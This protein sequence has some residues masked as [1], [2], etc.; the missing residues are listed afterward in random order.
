MAA[1]CVPERTSAASAAG[2]RAEETAEVRITED[3]G[4]LAVVAGSGT[5]SAS[6]P[7]PVATPAGAFDPLAPHTV[8]KRNGKYRTY[9]ADS[10]AFLRHWSSGAIQRD[11]SSGELY[12]VRDEGS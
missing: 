11:A 3:G 6:E 5:A 10:A 12:F 8:R 4:P 9:V 7:T 2:T 1:P